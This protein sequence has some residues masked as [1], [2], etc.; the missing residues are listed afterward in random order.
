MC[1]TR[2]YHTF[3]MW[4]LHKLFPPKFSVAVIQCRLH[5][6]TICH[7][8]SMA[9]VTSYSAMPCTPLYLRK[10]SFDLLSVCTSFL[11]LGL[12]LSFS[13]LIVCVFCWYFF[14]Y[15][16]LCSHLRVDFLLS[17]CRLHP[18]NRRRRVLLVCF[19]NLH[20]HYHNPHSWLLSDWL[21]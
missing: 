20:H 10:W 13:Q 21:C 6:I 7:D 16:L 1:R 8:V 11:L 4:S 9:V 14:S 17:D 5:A 12:P 2:T 19:V 3:P 15:A 18:I